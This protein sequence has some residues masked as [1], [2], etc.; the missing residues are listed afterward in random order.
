MWL[1]APKTNVPMLEHDS[2]VVQG[3]SAILD[4]VEAKLGGTRLAAPSGTSARARELEAQCD[5][6][7]GLGVQRILYDV[8]LRDPKVVIDLWGQDGPW[9]SG[10]FY[11]MA[12]PLM[13]KGIRDAYGVSD[14]KV[15]EM[16]DT[17]R[18]AVDE[19]DRAL[20]GNRYLF[21]DEGPSRVDIA[22]ASLF[23][24][25]CCPPE[26]ITRWPLQAPEHR[27]F[28]AEFE[29]R[30]TWDFVLRMYRDHRRAP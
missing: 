17:F 4:Y 16:K 7:F 11:R 13:A 29:G 8:L 5:H 27:V 30:P 3:S 10:A 6:A 20:E 21:G 1:R 28:Q 23:A 25:V 2:E 24:P 12:F 19:T 26:H 22:V 14:D 18:R 9:W 15:V